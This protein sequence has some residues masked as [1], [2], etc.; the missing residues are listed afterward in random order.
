MI[1]RKEYKI[2]S[3]SRTPAKSS[4]I[5]GHKIRLNTLKRAQFIQNVFSDHNAIKIEISNRNIPKMNTLPE[6]LEP[7]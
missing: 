1:L 3:K 7:E 5:P 6:H 2:E 4:H